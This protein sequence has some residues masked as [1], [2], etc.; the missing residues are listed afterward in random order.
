[1]CASFRA[2]GWMHIC[3]GEM[4]DWWD[5]TE[6]QQRGALHSHILCWF[7][8]RVLKPEYKALRAITRTAKGTD[9]KQRPKEQV[10]RPLHDYQE[11]PVC[12][13]A[14]LASTPG[15]LLYFHIDQ[16]NVYH[17]HHVGRIWCEMA[18]PHVKGARRWGGFDWVSLRMAG[19]V[20][21]VQ[22]RFYIHSCTT[23]YC[24]LN[25]SSCRFFVDP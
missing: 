2:C 7:K 24:L 13:Y 12:T 11:D 19:L 1:M 3:A 8:P 9:S 18:R 21:S 14:M 10:V 4:R 5:R 25:R 23:R 17:S 20:R 6:A 22:S 15:L 16:D